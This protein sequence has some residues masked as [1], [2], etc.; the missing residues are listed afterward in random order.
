MTG[1]DPDRLDDQQLMKELQ[2]IHRT[3]HD[4]LLHGSNEALRTHNMR[5]AQ[6]EGEYLRRHPRRP[7]AA[8]RTRDGARERG[9][10]AE[11]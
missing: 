2:T 11:C 9:L 10:A 6:L 8:G 5:M 4:T 1:V 7:I 3:R